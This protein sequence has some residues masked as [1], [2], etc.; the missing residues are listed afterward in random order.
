MAAAQ[1]AQIGFAKADL[2][3]TFSLTGNVGTFSTNIG[4][5]SLSDIFKHSTLGFGVGPAVQWNILNYGQITNNVRVQDAKFQEALITYQNTV[6][7]A[8]KEVEDGLNTFIQSRRQVE[9]LKASVT[10]A[11]GAL[12]IS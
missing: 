5:A 6:L 10:A 11:E 8:Q 9:F 7:N 1:C 3:P 12:K 4:R 2:L